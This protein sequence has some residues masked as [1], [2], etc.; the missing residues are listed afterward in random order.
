MNVLYIDIDSLRADHV[1]TY[2]YGPSTTPNIDDVA[3]DGV[4]F[5]NAY[6]AN[7]PCMPSRAA[8][9]SGRYGIN[10]GIETHGPSAQ[11]L[12]SPKSRKQWYACWAEEWEKDGREWL[13]ETN[14]ESRDWLTLPEM[15]FHERITTSAV[16][17][18][19][20][21]TAP[22]F[23]HL[24]HE[25]HQPQEP[26]R[27]GE[28]MQTPRA[29]DVVGLSLECLGRH[30]G[31]DF[32]HYVQFWDPHAPY[33][34]S[35]EDI[36]E[37]RD[38]ALPPHPT[39]ERIEAHQEWDAWRSAGQLGVSDRDDLGELL[40]H[41]DAE[42]SYVDRQLGRLFE[43]L[44]AE[45]AY[46]DTLIVITADHG[47][48]F[49][50]HGIYR[51]HW[52][53]HDGTQRVPLIVKPP[54]DTAVDTG[55]RQQLVTNVDVA[56][57]LAAYADLDAPA[58]WQGRSLRPVVRD[59][60]APWRDAI[61]FDHGLYTAQRAVRTDR[62]KFIRTYHPGFWGGVVPERQLYDMDSDPH[63]QEDLAATQPDVV[64]D[65]EERMSVW[66]QEHVG[67]EEDTLHAVAREGPAG[68][69]GQKDNWSGV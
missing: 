38:T 69:E 35:D 55:R 1:G 47:E 24:W 37:F 26:N 12:N 29:A 22:W 36:E 51:E 66:Q 30:L 54:A 3:D 46:D 63:E 11:N 8:F 33:N 61:V 62:W 21:H 40:A 23:Y 42:I 17:S 4:W 52:S 53:T 58:S 67:I 64:A 39:A 68:Y 2:G 65:L 50:E 15:F 7:S 34:R 20:R 56:P 48:E 9:I 16:S 13:A 18:F 43:F 27:R 31:D 28:Y 45:D 44:R 57:T 25:Y 10:N 5:E 59:P 41:Y 49:G 60:D 32:F 14:G 6:V 19:P